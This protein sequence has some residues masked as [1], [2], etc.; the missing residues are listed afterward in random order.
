MHLIQDF[1]LHN[2][3]KHYYVHLDEL[4]SPLKLESVGFGITF[5]KGSDLE[6]CIWIKD[7]WAYMSWIELS[8]WT[9]L[10]TSLV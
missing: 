9:L 4:Q 1:C 8:R 5:K 7:F 10:V 2:I 3:N 6:L